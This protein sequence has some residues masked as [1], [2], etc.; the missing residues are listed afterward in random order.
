MRLF[1]YI[2]VF[3][4]SLSC[5]AFA[6]ENTST[7]PNQALRI[8]S[9][10]TFARLDK[11]KSKLEQEPSYISVIIEEELLPYFDY[12]YAAYSVVGPNLKNT[13]EDQRNDF[14]EAFRIYLINAYGH[15]LSNYNQQTLQIL[16]N[17][18]FNDKNVVNIPVRMVDNNG[19]LTQL[20]FKLRKN[21]NTGYWKVFDVIAEGVSMLDTKRSEFSPLIQKKGIDEVIE[22][23]QQKNSEFAS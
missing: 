12:K 7:D 23:L 16:D 6:S 8:L 13:T 17:K 1:I 2:F 3:L 5:H 19:Q 21:N 18:N 10:N 14:V 4:Y 9:S 22:L 15:I 11:E 20:V